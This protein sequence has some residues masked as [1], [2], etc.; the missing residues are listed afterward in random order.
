MGETRRLG[1]AI[2]SHSKKRTLETT[3][4]GGHSPVTPGEE[5]GCNHKHPWPFLHQQGGEVGG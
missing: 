1:N 2:R 3:D 5:G 4:K